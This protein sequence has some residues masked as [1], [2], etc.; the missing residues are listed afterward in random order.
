M[1]SISAPSFQQWQR[2]LRFTQDTETLFDTIADARASAISEK[3]CDNAPALAWILRIDT[4]GVQLSCQRDVGGDYVVRTREWAS[5]ATIKKETTKVLGGTWDT[6][7]P[8]ILV[9]YTGGTQSLINDDYANKWARISIEFEDLGKK[10]TICY[11]QIANY[12]YF[13]K[14]GTCDDE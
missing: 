9:I 11:S 10:R 3:K 5:P 7:E 13:S 6:K 2:D 8:L 1:A 4:A 14:D 12:P